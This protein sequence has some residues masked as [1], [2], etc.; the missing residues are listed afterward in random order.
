MKKLLM[1]IGILSTIA[2]NANALALTRQEAIE[3]ADI[4]WKK[5]VRFAK[6]HKKKII[7]GGLA[8]VAAGLGAGAAAY[9][10]RKANRALASAGFESDHLGYSTTKVFMGTYGLF[11]ADK[12]VEW[13]LK[14]RELQ[15]L[16][17]GD[18]RRILNALAHFWGISYDELVKKIQ[19]AG[20]KMREKEEMIE[21]VI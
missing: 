15:Q 4:T 21:V 12:G 13:L 14:D 3:T 8:A 6:Q 16:M 9:V 11:G 2:I 19:E 5:I 18:A 20:K 17:R 1:M 10:N 7:A